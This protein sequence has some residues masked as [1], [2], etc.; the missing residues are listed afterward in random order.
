MTTTTEVRPPKR[1]S[2]APTGK[3]G[4]QLIQAP[5][6]RVIRDPAFA[7]RLESACDAHPH[8]PDKHRGRLGWLKEMMKKQGVEVSHETCRKWFAGEARPRPDKMNIL[9]QVLEV[10]PAWLAMGIDPELQ[11]H[12]RKVR[13]AMADGTVNL[14]AGFVQMDGGYPA[15]PDDDDPR[16]NA[17]NV[18]LYA[19]IRGVNY[20]FH[21]VLGEKTDAGLR[22][23]IPAAH[24]NVVVLGVIRLT[25]FQIQ[26]YELQGDVIRKFGNNRGGAI[27]V[28]A[29]PSDLRKID[30]F[31]ERL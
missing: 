25:S 10:D 12:E 11:P 13:N 28:V 9:A 17:D 19:I 23:L 6:A 21:V 16:A 7:H 15:F 31:R 20:G 14:I 5:Q 18:D 30:N 22:F 27:E 8:A 1:S 4:S 2:V 24:T 3:P 29:E 26:V